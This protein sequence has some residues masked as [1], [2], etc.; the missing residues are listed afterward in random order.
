MFLS[1]HSKNLLISCNTQ[2]E[3]RG[4]NTDHLPIV[5]KLKLSIGTNEEK[6]THNFQEVDWE[7]FN[8]ALEEQ[9]AK[10]H[11]PTVTHGL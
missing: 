8:K 4:I 10:L 7:G 1:D 9:L 5:T 6:P 11:P 3:H 2:T